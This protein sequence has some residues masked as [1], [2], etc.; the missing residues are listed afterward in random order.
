METIEAYKTSDGK[1]FENEFDAMQHEKHINFIMNVAALI[2]KSDIAYDENRKMV[3]DFIVEN[4]D[5]LKVIFDIYVVG[6]IN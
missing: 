5:N 4:F 1:I 2:E 6:L 3:K